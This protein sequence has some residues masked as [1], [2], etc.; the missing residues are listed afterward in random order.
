[1]GVTKG[2]QACVFAILFL[3]QLKHRIEI[4]KDE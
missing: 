4:M 1:M 3:T 2:V